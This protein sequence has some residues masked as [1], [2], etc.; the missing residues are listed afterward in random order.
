MGEIKTTID[1]SRDL[2]V[3]TATGALSIDE[4]LSA[5]KGYLSGEP[6]GKV[7]WNLLEA[8]GSDWSHVELQ[9]LHQSLRK[10]PIVF[11][12]RRKIA[13]A[14]SR[15]LGFGLSRISRTYAKIASIPADYYIARSIEEA[16]SWLD[17]KTIRNNP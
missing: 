1:R 7:L 17:G 9:R 8:D 15:D 11:S 14:V 13:L 5:V 4:I 3:N 6:T 10:I 16:M 12:K 2:T